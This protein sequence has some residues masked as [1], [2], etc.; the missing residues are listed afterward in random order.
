MSRH[1]PAGGRGS[2]TVGPDGTVVVPKEAPPGSRAAPF[3]VACTGATTSESAGG[4][5][6]LN[7]FGTTILGRADP[8]PEC[9]SVVARKW[10]TLFFVPVGPIGRYR[11]IYTSRG[12]FG[13]SG[14]FYSRAL[15]ERSPQGRGGMPAGSQGHR[16]TSPR[17]L[18]LLGLIAAV[19]LLAVVTAVYNKPARPEYG[20][21]E[22][23]SPRLTTLPST[24]PRATAAKA[25][26]DRCVAFGPASFSFDARDLVPLLHKPPPATGAVQLSILGVT[27]IPASFKSPL[28]GTPEITAAGRFIGIRMEVANG[29]D[30]PVQPGS[31]LDFLTLHD[32]T[33]SWRRADYAAGHN[34]VSGAWRSVTTTV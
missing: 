20:L 18:S 27:E 7:G 17:T 13:G 32:G 1:R 8:C 15:K 22:Q 2:F 30:T 14:S 11:V 9:G 24:A 12:L 6:R 4:A 29:A 5:F 25:A 28:R 26:S 33:T 19:V 23:T 16:R 34:E 21:P 31:Q 3:C 10:V